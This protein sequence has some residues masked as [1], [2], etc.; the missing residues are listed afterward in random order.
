MGPPRHDNLFKVLYP[1]V[2]L[3]QLER[4]GGAL[5]LCFPIT[6]SF[7]LSRLLFSRSISIHSFFVVV[8]V[9]QFGFEHL[10]CSEWCS[11]RCLSFWCGVCVCVCCNVCALGC[12][13][14][15]EGG[16]KRD[17]LASRWCVFSWHLFACL[18]FYLYEDR[19]FHISRVASCGNT[20]FFKKLYIVCF[21][22]FF[23]F[24]LQIDQLVVNF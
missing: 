10:I 7:S 2:P 22:N 8:L 18:L 17:V 21:L 23:I 3:L 15:E 5:F 12:Q 9:F 24:F 13:R 4:R 19:R 14:R 11:F 16:K 1:L 20:F 6:L